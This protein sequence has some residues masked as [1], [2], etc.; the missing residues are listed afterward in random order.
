VVALLPFVVPEVGVSVRSALLLLFL[1]AVQ[2]AGAYA[3]FLYGIRHVTAARAALVGMLEPVA[4]PLWVLLAL[5]ERPRGTAVVGG[6]VVLSAIA[7]RTVLAA[8][9]ER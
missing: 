1:G 7:W 8:R 2:I 5:G 3:L 9:T 6:F 4:N